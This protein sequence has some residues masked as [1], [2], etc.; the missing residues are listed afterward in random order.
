M[1]RKNGKSRLIGDADRFG[2]LCHLS[3]TLA[4]A[5][6]LME[7]AR[8]LAQLEGTESVLQEC[9][10]IEEVIERLKAELADCVSSMID[11]E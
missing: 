5:S 8:L 7:D 4:F 11:K 3:T 10:K 1:K 9:I 2:N 6:R